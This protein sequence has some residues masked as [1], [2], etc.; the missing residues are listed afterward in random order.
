[1][2][3]QAAGVPISIKQLKPNAPVSRIRAIVVFQVRREIAEKRE[4]AKKREIAD[5]REKFITANSD[6]FTNA[7]AIVKHLETLWKLDV[8]ISLLS[9]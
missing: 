6:P 2:P 5:H 1:M 8:S 7:D 3:A 9:L 4:I